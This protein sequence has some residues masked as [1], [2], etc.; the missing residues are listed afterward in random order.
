MKV[1]YI[2]R[3]YNIP[4]DFKEILEKKLKKLDKYFDKGVTAKIVCN[5]QKDLYILEV[6][7]NASGLFFRSEVSSDNM[8]SNIDLALPKI[9]KQITKNSD[10][11]KTKMKK[12]TVTGNIF[13]E[14]SATE[15]PKN[16]VK[17]KRFEIEPMTIEEAEY[18]MEALGHTFF[19]FINVYTNEV[20]VL[21]K[22]NDGNI[23][24]IEVV[25]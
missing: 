13:V 9:E 1:S 15:T 10:R 20:N 18:R 19:I 14:G 22:R 6:T 17:T 23:G 21:Y 2:S 8:F 4:K 11:F 12:D 3:N 5:K 25:Y 24:N 7:I 16:L